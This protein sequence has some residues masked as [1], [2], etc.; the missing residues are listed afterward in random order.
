MLTYIVE[1]PLDDKPAE[2]IQGLKRLIGSF[3]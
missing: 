2:K 3:G 1:K